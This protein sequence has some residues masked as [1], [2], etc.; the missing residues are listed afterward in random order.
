MEQVRGVRLNHNG[1]TCGTVLEAMYS[2][3]R[4]TSFSILPGA[5][6]CMLSSAFDFQLRNALDS[7]FPGA[8]DSQLPRSVGSRLQSSKCFTIVLPLTTKSKATGEDL[9]LTK[10]SCPFH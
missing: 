7:M 10:N 6:D 1:S 8:V 2:T 4:Y 5:L 9:P 3:G